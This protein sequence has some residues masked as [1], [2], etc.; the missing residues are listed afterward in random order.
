M[1]HIKIAVA[2]L[3]ALGCFAF[4]MPGSYGKKDIKLSEFKLT[5]LDGNPVASESLQ[6]KTVFL[7]IWATWCGPCISEMPSIAQARQKLGPDVVFLLASDETPD[8]IRK[9]E[10]RR[11]TGLPLVHFANSSDFNFNAIPLTFIFDGKGQLKHR[12]LGARDWSK[13]DA[14]KLF[15]K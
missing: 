6:G 11:K 3:L 7:N 4:F 1:R 14:L 15:V 2:L 5:D 13:P 10:E 9:F 12:E 8:R